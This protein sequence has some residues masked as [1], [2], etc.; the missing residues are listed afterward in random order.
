MLLQLLDAVWQLT[1]QYP[2]AFEFNE[3]ALRFIALH[4]YSGSVG[5][6]VHDTDLARLSSRMCTGSASGS[7]QL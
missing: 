6:F 7:T 1:Q 3:K 5:T 4:I 2:T